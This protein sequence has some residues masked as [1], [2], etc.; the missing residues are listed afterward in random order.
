MR[1]ITKE[2]RT[3]QRS[4]IRARVLMHDFLPVPILPASS[5]PYLPASS[6][7]N[8]GPRFFLL[9]QP[10]IPVKRKVN[11]KVTSIICAIQNGKI[12]KKKKKKTEKEGVRPQ[13]P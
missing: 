4:G 5:S 8:L 9:P 10:E 7:L 2:R 6:Y 12:K 1:I 3:D 13:I 11:T